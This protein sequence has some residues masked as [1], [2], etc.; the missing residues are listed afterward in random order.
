MINTG[1]VLINFTIGF[2]NNLFQYVCGRLLAERNN[3]QL[4]HRAIPEMMIPEKNPQINS[5]LPTIVVDDK[6]YKK[7]SFNTS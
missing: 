3:L 2:G 7:I 5:S 6:N 1:T 4:K